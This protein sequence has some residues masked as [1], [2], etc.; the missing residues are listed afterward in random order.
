MPMG[1]VGDSRSIFW[2]NNRP[3]SGVV[4][5]YSR[6]TLALMSSLNADIER[7]LQPAEFEAGVPRRLSQLRKRAP[8]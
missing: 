4:T 7:N 5:T 1:L 2:E 6:S 8:L 3:C